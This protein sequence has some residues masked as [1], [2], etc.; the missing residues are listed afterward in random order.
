MFG[1]GCESDRSRV[2]EILQVQTVAQE[3]K[4]LGLPTPQGRL[5]KDSFKTTKERLSKKLSPWIERH[6]SSS[7]KEVLIK[8][9]AQAIPMYRPENSFVSTG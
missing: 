6:M 9:I 7:E 8:S 3:E 2:M 1:A 5:G 4:Y